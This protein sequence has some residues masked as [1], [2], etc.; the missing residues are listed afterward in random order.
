MALKLI[1]WNERWPSSLEDAI[2]CQI[3]KG[4]TGRENDL[5]RL[6]RRVDEMAAILA[7]LLEHM[8]DF[9]HNPSNSEIAKIIGRDWTVAKDEGE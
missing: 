7:R 2:L 1:Q 9:R 5:S 6:E 4:M 8:N 3:N